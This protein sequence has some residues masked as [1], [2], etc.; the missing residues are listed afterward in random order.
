MRPNEPNER[1]YVRSLRRLDV[2]GFRLYEGFYDPAREVPAQPHEWATLTLA[3]EGGY[4]VDW[5][6]T[7]LDCGPASLVFHP[8]GEVYGARISDAGS[9]CLTVRIDPVVL[10]S[11]AELVPDLAGLHAAR[12]A[13]P[14]WL[15]FELRRELELSDDLSGASVESAVVALLVELGER[16]GLEARSAPPPWLERVREQIHDEFR[17][18][19]T[20]ET[21]ARTASVH[22]VHLA[23]E[24]RRRFGCT[25]GQYIRQRRVEFACHRLTGT[26]T[27]LSRIAFEAGF[28]DQSHFTKTFR[29]LVGLTPAVFRERFGTPPRR[30]EARAAER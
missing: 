24:F 3:V 25:V 5:F 10:R 6:G 26:Q 18:R 20:L 9:R 7:R 29:Q 17:R 28:A 8:P 14:R 21:L 13:P 12:R 27:P 1:D 4:Q 22:R 16:P 23:R 19:H 2:P 11:A 30:W 15:A